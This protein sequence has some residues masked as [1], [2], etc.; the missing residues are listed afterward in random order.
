MT[1]QVLTANPIYG[2]YPIEITSYKLGPFTTWLINP[3]SIRS[4]RSYVYHK[5][6]WLVVWNM[7]FIFHILGISSS[8]L[9]KSY[10]SEGFCS[11][12][13]TSIEFSHSVGNW[14]GLCYPL[15]FNSSLLNMAIEIV[16][17]PIE[18]GGSFQ[19][20]FCKRLPGRVPRIVACSR[21]VQL[22]R[23]AVSKCTWHARHPNCAFFRS[24]QRQPEG[25]W[26]GAM[27]LRETLGCHWFDL[28]FI[29][30][31]PSNNGF[32]PAN[33]NVFLIVVI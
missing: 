24:V 10:F 22:Y 1:L 2:M 27:K 28:I 6:Y 31:W 9:T 16:D 5:P 14:M 3:L 20:V 19:F 15:V 17:F 4:I 11:K 33:N 25:E 12:P 18:N 21:S 7:N 29:I 8:Q 26:N 30:L 13:P 32:N 23:A